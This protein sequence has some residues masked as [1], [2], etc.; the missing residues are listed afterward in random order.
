ME[1]PHP[2]IADHALVLDTLTLA[3]EIHPGQRNSLDALCK[4]YSVDNSHRVLHGALL[5]AEILADVFL[6]MTG[7][8]SELSFAGQTSKL[9]DRQ[10]GEVVAV[11]QNSSDD[12]LVIYANDDEAMLHQQWLDALER[13]KLPPEA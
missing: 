1:H 6:L 4:R 7:G 8:Q 13:D 11:D 3:R 5:D 9:E 10:R 2:V 12:L